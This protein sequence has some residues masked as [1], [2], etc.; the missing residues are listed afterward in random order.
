MKG[1]L[2]STTD[3]SH[4]E[5]LTNKQ[6]QTMLPIANQP[7]MALAISVLA[8]HG[9][10]QLTAVLHDRPSSVAAYFG[11]GA[12]WGVALNHETPAPHFGTVGILQAQADWLDETFVILPAD[13]IIDLD[14]TAVLTHHQSH[15]APVTAVLQADGQTPTGCFV[16]DTAVLAHL[17]ND[18]TA[19]LWDSLQAQNMP[20]QT[21][22]LTGIYNPLSSFS[23]YHAANIGYLHSYQPDGS[24]PSFQHPIYD[25]QQYAPGVWV[26]RNPIIHPSVK[27]VPP[28]YI[29]DGCR[30]G[31]DVELGPGVV[32][33]DNVIID[34][35]ATVQES[36][37][38]ANTYVGQL[39][40]IHQRIVSQNKLVDANTNKA[41][42]LVDRFLLT[43][44]SPAAASDIIRRNLDALAAAL[45]IVLLLPLWLLLGLGTFLINGRLLS[46]TQV[47]GTRP[48][49]A[50]KAAGQH[51]F[52]MPI[53]AAY[54]RQGQLTGWGR[55]LLRWELHRLP[56]LFSVFVGNMAIVGVMPL[57]SEEAA[58]V[59]EAWQ[60]RRYE[61]PMGFTG[62][63]FVQC[64]AD[65]SLDEIL[66]TDAFYVST[67]TWREDWRLLRQTPAAW[68]RR[69][70]IKANLS[71]VK[72][73]AI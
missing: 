11:D 18:P 57:A 66:I 23:D 17:P 36:V 26:G 43:E 67:R 73:A 16:C 41:I 33:G 5:P 29:G 6:P 46:R 35:E 54:N 1:L 37:I 30:I 49:S 34:D 64:A 10:K 58:N 55:W 47:T 20:L 48:W 14:L 19:D 53:F 72:R 51:E 70:T 69:A 52:N 9:V 68:W 62:L 44:N 45:L 8:R 71:A 3:G 38:L 24:Q 2:I 59:Q 32:I 22:Q 42:E 7:V 4:L 56:S 13:V 40:N 65:A 31:R 15:S 12:R 60:T 61:S 50:N 39:V 25:G 27:I 28:L 21:I 63:W